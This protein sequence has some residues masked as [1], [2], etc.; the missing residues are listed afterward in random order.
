MQHHCE[1][2]LYL[3][4]NF[5]KVFN[6]FRFWEL[7]RNHPGVK[8]SVDRVSLIDM[9][10]TEWHCLYNVNFYILIYSGTDAHL[11]HLFINIPLLF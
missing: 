3:T 11:L 7:Y 8:P 6:K 9:R 1:S 5:S 10:I 4:L 2:G